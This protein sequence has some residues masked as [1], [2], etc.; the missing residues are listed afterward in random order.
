MRFPRLIVTLALSFDMALHSA[1]A[2]VVPANELTRAVASTGA[3]SVQAA[4][5]D[6]FLRA[7]GSVLITKK[8]RNYPTYVSAAVK[9]RKDLADKIVATTLT[10]CRLNQPASGKQFRLDA[11]KIVAAA[12][13]ANPDAAADI[14]RAA[15]LAEPES[16]DFIIAAA[17]KAAPEQRWAILDAAG[18]IMKTVSTTFFGPGNINPVDIGPEIR[19]TSPEQ[20]PRGP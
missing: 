12:V 11:A 1:M 10:I 13:E 7:F 15:L 19:I 20:P 3:T 14:V 17:I 6:Q 4:N 8:A 9:L 18:E 16:R 5:T 2:T